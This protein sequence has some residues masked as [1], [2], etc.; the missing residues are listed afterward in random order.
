MNDKAALVTC[1]LAITLVAGCDMPRESGPSINPNSTFRDSAKERG[2]KPERPVYA[3]PEPKVHPLTKV[4]RAYPQDDYEVAVL[5][6]YEIM[7]TPDAT[8]A[9]CARWFPLHGR[10]TADA[11]AEWQKKQEP[12]MNEIRDRTHAIWIRQADGDASVV[13]WAEGRF[14]RDRA[15]QYLNAFDKI[16][17][18]TYE[19]RCVDL[20][21]AL[22]S[23][24]WDLKK[25]FRQQLAIVRKHPMR[26][27][28]AS[29]ATAAN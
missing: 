29:A 19:K 12:L 2:K 18:K 27:S 15:Q 1:L 4:L 25:R 11:V 10:Q 8:Q 9:I 26:D 21:A 17:V 6:M 7:H 5:Y 24:T 20:P 28:A 16:P 23:S 3:M 14:D 22:R 13:P